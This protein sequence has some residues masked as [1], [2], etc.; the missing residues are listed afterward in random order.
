MKDEDKIGMAP[1]DQLSFLC[2]E[3]Q[4][5]IKQIEDEYDKS[6]ED[7]KERR[8]NIL[9]YDNDL[10][11]ANVLCGD[12]IHNARKQRYTSLISLREFWGDFFY[13]NP[14]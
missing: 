9:K 13:D 11:K 2:P 5:A 14:R 12:L 4:I 6:C 3:L 1:L 10:F 7:A 8:K